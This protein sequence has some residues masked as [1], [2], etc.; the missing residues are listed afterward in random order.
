MAPPTHSSGNVQSGT[1][2]HHVRQGSVPPSGTA[3]RIPEER[4]KGPIDKYLASIPPKTL[5]SSS[6]APRPRHEGEFDLEKVEVAPGEV[7][8]D[9]NDLIA[10]IR[11]T[12]DE[13]AESFNEADMI[14][15]DFDPQYKL[16]PWQVQGRH[17]M[18]NRET[19]GKRGGI[20]ADDVSK[21]LPKANSD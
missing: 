7:V 11:S 17:W 2:M 3:I 15:P 1:F 20:L 12:A 18:I 6:S 13:V 21:N 5:G 14:V 9:W 8:G 19:N 10:N 16:R 4:S